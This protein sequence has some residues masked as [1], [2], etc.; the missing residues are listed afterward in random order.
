MEKLVL[1]LDLKVENLHQRK[2][3]DGNWSSAIFFMSGLMIHNKA[4][5][6][7]VAGDGSVLVQDI[8]S[9]QM[10]KR[11]MIFAFTTFS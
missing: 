5:V 6:Y 7:L 3:L 1:I 11:Q 9:L 2:I 8:H 4:P 10:G